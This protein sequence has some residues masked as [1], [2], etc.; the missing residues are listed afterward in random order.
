MINSILKDLGF[1]G[2]T[3]TKPTPAPSHIRLDRDLN[4]KE[5]E[6]DFHYRRVIGKMNFLEKSTRPDI[7]YAVHQC[8]RFA[9]EPKQSH[10]TAVKYIGKYLQGTAEEGIIL[11]PTD[12]SFD[13]WVDA[14]FVGNWNKATAEFDPSVAKSRTGYVITYGSCPLVWGSRLQREVALSSTEAEYNAV[15]ESMRD[16]IHLMQLIKDMQQTGLNM[17]K[18]PPKVHCKVY[19][20]NS[21]ALEMVR[22]PKMRPRTRHMAVRL[23]HFRE[24]VRTKQVSISKVPSRYQLGDLLTKPQPKDLFE[25]QRESNLQ[26]DSANKSARELT[27]PGKHLKACEIIESLHG[28]NKSATP[29]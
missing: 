5:M 13:C 15:S 28:L 21:G 2:R 12:H 7:A 3:K 19:E 14:D 9:A 25:S 4:G 10:A 11:N 8:A 20:D 18:D 23:H 24:Y 29:K 16:V 26:W 22:L 27:L 1:N 17:V 6:D